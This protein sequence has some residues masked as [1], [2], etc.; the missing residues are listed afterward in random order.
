MAMYDLRLNSNEV[1]RILLAL[2]N[3][4]SDEALRTRETLLTQRNERSNNY[5]VGHQG[6]ATGYDGRTGV[7]AV[8][9]AQTD[10]EG[11]ER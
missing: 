1:T 2:E 4:S 3:D 10:D 5:G 6:D 7:G 11:G 9:A 8:L